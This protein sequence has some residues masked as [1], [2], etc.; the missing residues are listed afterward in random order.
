MSIAS[1]RAASA[2]A[3]TTLALAS[4]FAPAAR[5][6]DDCG[7]VDACQRTPTC[8]SGFALTGAPLGLPPGSFFC[9]D[10]VEAAVSNPTCGPENGNDDWTW[11][12]GAKKCTRTN[13]SGTKVFSSDN[14]KCPS[15]TNAL[16][17]VANMPTIA[18]QTPARTDFTA[19]ALATGAAGAHYRF[20]DVAK[21]ADAI[22]TVLCTNGF[23]LKKTGASYY[24]ELYL[25]A[26]TDEAPTCADFNNKDWTWDA[27]AKA[28]T[29]SAKGETFQQTQNI[30]CDPYATYA[31]GSGRCVTPKG[32]YYLAPRLVD[33]TK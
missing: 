29:R 19:P 25:T 1:I 10:E 9:K 3:L 2:A 14:A 4:T 28:C 30:T 27:N 13:K 33:P 31:A 32:T 15:G 18:C 23:S 26:A 7:S 22:R 8:K 5:A 16:P 21:Q 12:N 20:D 24:C 17:G 11:D 6:G